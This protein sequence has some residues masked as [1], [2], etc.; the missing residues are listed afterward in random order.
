MVVTTENIY[1]FSC[2]DHYQLC[3]HYIYFL[4]QN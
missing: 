4:S 3:I 2:D 1:V